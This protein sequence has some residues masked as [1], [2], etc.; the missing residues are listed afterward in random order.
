MTGILV[1]LFCLRVTIL[2]ITWA[3]DSTGGMGVLWLGTLYVV[4]AWLRLTGWGLTKNYLHGVIYA[5]MSFILVG[6]KG[7]LLRFGVPESYADKLYGYPSIVV[8]IESV[9][10]F[11]FFCNLPRVSEKVGKWICIVSKHSFSVY[12]IHFAM[13]G[14]LFTTIAGLDKL[15]GRPTVF[16][17]VMILFC[18]VVFI[19][20]VI[21]DIGKAK[22]FSLIRKPHQVKSIEGKI[23]NMLNGF[24]E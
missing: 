4:G 7:I 6:S 3:Q 17:P 23:D 16:L 20:C 18:M 1:A 24:V 19:A 14:T 21:V 5:L 13:V 22:L 10:L 9:A 11:L 2:P 8:L 12:I 15:H